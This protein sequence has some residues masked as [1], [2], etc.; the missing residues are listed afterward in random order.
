ML[1]KGGAKSWLVLTSVAVVLAVA[2]GPALAGTASASPAPAA[3]V[4]PSGDWA[5]GGMGYS[6]GTVTIGNTT[7]TWNATFGSTAIVTV[8]STGPETA[9]Y[10]LQRTLGIQ[11]TAT[12]TNPKL[13]A[14]YSYHAVEKDTAFANLT[15][16]STVYVNGNPVPARGLENDATFA[17][18]SIAEALSVTRDGMTK[19]ASLNVEGWANTSAVFTPAL[20]LIP[21][22]LSGISQWN[23]TAQVAANGQWNILWS[24]SDDGVLGT[25][26]SGSGSQSG[27]VSPSGTVTLTGYNVTTRAPVP[28]FVDHKQR[29]AVVLVIQGPL[30][31]YDLFV[32]EPSAFLLF[33]GGAHEFD[34]V[35]LGSA[36]VSSQQFYVSGGNADPSVTA[37]STTIAATNGAASAGSG[38]ADPSDSPGA[39][40]VEQPMTVAAAQNEANCLSNGCPAAAGALNLGLVVV[41]ALV[42]V[43]AVG[44]V[45]VIEWRSY[46]RRRNQTTGL[47]G[48]YAE[49]WASGVPPSSPSATPPNA[50]SQAPTGPAGAGQP[51]R[52]S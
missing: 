5:Y 29:Q 39:T 46:A 22:N 8:T 40:V 37:A 28:L 41:V 15:N 2:I 52:Q 13:D 36:T 20:G 4:H 34:S 21:L 19:S 27:S 49:H 42:I 38:P 32:L 51:P 17:Y 31:F 1:A 26:G 24:W 3:T 10:E 9:E 23:S 45:A 47:V 30:G 18:G 43:A 25:T 44:A 35:A 11:L 48:G 7:I 33:G 14:S 12:L 16:A 6:N 50:G